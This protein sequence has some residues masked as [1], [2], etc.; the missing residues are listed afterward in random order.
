MRESQC[1]SPEAIAQSIRSETEISTD[2]RMGMGDVTL[3]ADELLAWSDTTAEHWKRLIE[4]HPEAL[5]LPCDVCRGQDG[6]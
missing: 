2:R 4:A 3:S 6:R 1:Q 5:Q